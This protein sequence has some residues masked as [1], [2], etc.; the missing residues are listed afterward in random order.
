MLIPSATVI[1]H[2]K[3]AGISV[4]RVLH[5]GAHD[6]QEA[7][8][9]RELGI[10]PEN[11]VWVDA[12]DAKIAQ[13][14]RRNIP[15][16]YKAVITDVDNADIT[17]N[18][19]NNEQSSSV[20]ELG[21]HKEEHPDVHYVQSIQEKTTTI[22]TFLQRETIDPAF[23]F[24]NLDIQG[25]ELL[26]LKG[27]E[28]ALKHASALY[29]E[30]NEKALYKGCPLIGELD[31]YLLERGFRRV[32]TTMTSHGW[33]DALYL[34]TVPRILML[35]LASDDGAL[36]SGLQAIW[37]LYM[38]SEPKIDCY[39]IKDRE[40]QEEPFVL[41][42]KSLYIKTYKGY[43]D[44]DSLWIKTLRAFEYFQSTL[45][46]YDYVFRPNLSSFIRFDAY[47]RFCKGLPRTGLYSGQVNTDYGLQ[48]ASGCGFTL[49][50]DLVKRLI[51]TPPKHFVIDDLTIGTAMRDWGIPIV[52]APRHTIQPDNLVIADET[53]LPKLDAILENPGDVYHY[54]VRTGDAGRLERDL[55]IHRALSKRFYDNVLCQVK[56][57]S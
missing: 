19:S 50:T 6:C 25:A 29:L 12:L 56:C 48:Y 8:F 49:S 26:A 5:I 7:G 45:D 41:E 55:T 33:G 11:T 44:N 43:A 40:G 51:A 52:E 23:D 37:K 10:S 2:L 3:S 18:V 28:Q 4:S 42:G 35:V 14:K 21:T 15:N 31:A 20:L 16:V 1:R 30:V 13:A 54:R 32:E 36:Y 27:G 38:D 57:L 39:F 24:W 46:S 9:Y 53:S 34:R 47:L 17:F 22:D